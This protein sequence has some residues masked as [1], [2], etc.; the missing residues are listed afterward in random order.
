VRLAIRSNGL[1]QNFGEW[2]SWGCPQGTALIKKNKQFGCQNQL[3]DRLDWKYYACFINSNRPIA[4]RVNPLFDQSSH[5]S[6]YEIALFELHLY[7][8]ICMG[9]KF[10]SFSRTGIAFA[11]GL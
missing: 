3:A 4:L 9:A 6:Q 7:M 10:N 8:P 5:N 1:R 2:L 11:M